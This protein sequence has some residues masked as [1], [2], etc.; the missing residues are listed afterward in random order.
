MPQV[1]NSEA[2]YK[3]RILTTEQ[4]NDHFKPERMFKEDLIQNVKTLT[5]LKNQGYQYKTYSWEEQWQGT[6]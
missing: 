6:S 3:A 2:W 4:K 1:Q 5:L